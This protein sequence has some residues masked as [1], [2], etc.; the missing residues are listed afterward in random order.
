MIETLD[1]LDEAVAS[2]I[3]NYGLEL[4]DDDLRP[5][6]EMFG[7]PYVALAVLTNY[8]IDRKEIAAWDQW[9]DRELFL[10]LLD[11]RKAE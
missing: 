1:A 4:S 8:F 5:F 6:A 2:N 3:P 10:K 11:E 9:P 7:V